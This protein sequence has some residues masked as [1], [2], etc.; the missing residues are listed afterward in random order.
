[1]VGRGLRKLRL[2]TVNGLRFRALVGAARETLRTEK[3]FEAAGASGAGAAS[4]TG[5]AA[6]GGGAAAEFR[7]ARQ[8]DIRLVRMPSSAITATK[9]APV[10][11]RIATNGGWRHQIATIRCH[12]SAHPALLMPLAPK[13]NH[14]WA[15]LCTNRAALPCGDAAAVA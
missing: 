6:R 4:A 1:M 12:T 5:S 13:P 14:P 2:A 11:I 7:C 10:A 9:T 8:I 3:L 15:I